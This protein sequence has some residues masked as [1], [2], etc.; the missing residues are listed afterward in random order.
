[1]EFCPSCGRLVSPESP[2]CSACGANL[3]QR[4]SSSSSSRQPYSVGTTYSAPRKDPRLA[5]ALA[6]ILGFFGLWGVGQI[7]AGSLARGLGLFVVG[8]II[9]GL[10]WL[11][12]I[13]TVILIGYIGM[14]L[15]GILFVGGWLWQAA[16]AYSAAQAYNE[17][18][19]S[20]ARSQW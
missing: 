2:Y 18:H 15:F 19:A 17:L 6:L 3:R 7:Y 14:V 12:V 11:S 13:L 16:D 1:M 8:L 20:T 4:Y 10:F 5:A 9:G